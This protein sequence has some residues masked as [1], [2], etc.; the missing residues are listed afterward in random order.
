MTFMETLAVQLASGKV[1]CDPGDG[2][3]TQYF[4]GGGLT[5]SGIWIP[6]QMDEGGSLIVTD[7]ATPPL[8]S[9]NLTAVPASV[10]SVVLL[11]ANPAREGVIFF[12]N[13]DSICY[14]AFADESMNEL[15]T[16]LLEG[17]ATY[18]MDAPIYQGVISGIWV[19]ATGQMQVT[20][21]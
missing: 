14:L 4:P 19:T 7:M 12:N 1:L 21:L 18:S 15:F 17:G 5:S 11:A 2:V 6:F 16:E 20:E 9:A 10:S 8:V 13:S 3:Y